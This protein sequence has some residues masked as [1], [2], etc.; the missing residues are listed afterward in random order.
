MQR[1]RRPLA[2][3][4]FSASSAVWASSSRFEERRIIL[5]A[6]I[7]KEGCRVWYTLSIR[8]NPPKLVFAFIQAPISL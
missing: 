7:V 8:R 2:C 1:A 3:P 6:F 5:G 4:A